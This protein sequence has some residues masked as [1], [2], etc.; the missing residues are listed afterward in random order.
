ME[1]EKKQESSELRDG[2]PV[3]VR[4]GRTPQSS[5]EKEEDI[6]DPSTVESVGY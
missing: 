5:E 1:D 2:R 4:E 6:P 3:E